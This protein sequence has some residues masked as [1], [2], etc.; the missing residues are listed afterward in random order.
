[1]DRCCA[2]AAYRNNVIVAMALWIDS[3]AVVY[4]HLAASAPEGYEAQAMYGIVAAAL[5]VFTD[6]Q[7]IELG[8]PAG[9]SSDPDAGLAYFKRGFA[10]RE[11]DAYF[12]GACLHAERYALLTAGSPAT[13]FFPA[14]RQP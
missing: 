1:M 12:C 7:I 2:I 10:N 13:T 14:Y 8:G 5:E 6:A 3:G 11:I 9:L 4:Y